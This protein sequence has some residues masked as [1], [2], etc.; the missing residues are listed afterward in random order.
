MY[1]LSVFSVFDYYD[2]RRCL[3]DY[4]QYRKSINSRFSYRGFAT[5]A[6]YKS[7]G[8]FI[9]LVQGKQN[10]T[11]KALP[12]FIRAMGLTELEAEYFEMMVHFTHAPRAV[13]R[14]YWFD[15]MLRLLP[16]KAK[17]VTKEQEKY[18]GKW[19]H[20]AVCNAL[21]I[22]DIGEDYH[23]LAEFMQ[24]AM[25]LGQARE[26]IALLEGLGMIRKDDRGHWRPT[27]II[28]EPS[29]DLEP[30]AIRSYQESV[31]EL[32]KSA[33][34]THGHND[35]N[36]ACF[37]ISLSTEGH[38]RLLLKFDSFFGEVFQL[39]RSDKGANRVFQLNTHFFPLSKKNGS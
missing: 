37:T 6:G 15:K 39:V 25:T 8:L 38:H 28:V 5:K 12:G 22:L 17:T 11:R 26:S 21:S 16:A 4:Y 10:L 36:L 29:P 18:F 34:K 23:N 1:D 30:S 33:L 3:K 27:E 19:Q 24:P 35:H 7:S 20:G 2:Y 9:E 14:Q 13:A 31:I 32:G